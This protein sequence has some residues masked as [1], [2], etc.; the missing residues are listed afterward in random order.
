MANWWI[1]DISTCLLIQE[2]GLCHWFACG[3]CRDGQEGEDSCE[4]EPSTANMFDM[5]VYRELLL[6]LVIIVCLIMGMGH[7]P[8]DFDGYD[9]WHHGCFFLGTFSW[10]HAISQSN[11][12]HSR[13][14][15]WLALLKDH[16][17]N[18][19]DFSLICTG[20]AQNLKYDEHLMFCRV[21]WSQWLVIDHVNVTCATCAW[22]VQ[23]KL[24]LKSA[25]AGWGFQGGFHRPW[26][27]V[28]ICHPKVSSY[29]MILMDDQKRDQNT[30]G[31]GHG[32]RSRLRIERWKMGKMVHGAIL[33]HTIRIDLTGIFTAD[34]HAG[35]CESYSISSR[36]GLELGHIC[37]M[38][39]DFCISCC[40][41]NPNPPDLQLQLIQHG[42]PVAKVHLKFDF[43][44]QAMASPKQSKWIRIHQVLQKHCKRD[45]FA[46]E[47]IAMLLSVANLAIARHFSIADYCGLNGDFMRRR[48]QYWGPSPPALSPTKG[49]TTPRVAGVCVGSGYYNISGWCNACSFQYPRPFSYFHLDLPGLHL[50]RST[51]GIV[52]LGGSDA[53]RPWH[54]PAHARDVFTHSS[55][56]GWLIIPCWLLIILGVFTAL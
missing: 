44:S 38:H 4:A 50:H 24:A 47:I 19:G 8:F 10:D 52:L 54:H 51:A 45:E 29:G 37:H 30:H 56:G 1:W 42:Q 25:E 5:F 55:T 41:N 7:G 13:V 12:A 17:G 39:S 16:L 14:A 21:F 48:S 40:K 11:S 23:G 2:R 3:F 18:T 9:A 49:A 34:L 35:S 31:F 33:I 20:F 53:C 26:G 43:C 27:M 28:T 36:S 6:S 22:R 46:L 32:W 15:G